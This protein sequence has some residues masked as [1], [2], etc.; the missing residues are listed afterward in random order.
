MSFSPPIFFKK[1]QLSSPL[2]IRIRGEAR[3]LIL[4]E[5]IIQQKINSLKPEELVSYA[6]QY[7]I[8][9]SIN[10][11]KQLLQLVQGK[12]I[13]VFHEEERIALLKQ[14]AK[15]TSP[16]TAKKANQL[17]LQFFNGNWK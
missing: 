11:A 10:E 14:I 8:S 12:K 13:N 4:F 15:I 2:F 5:K 16:E 9:I 6:K 7:D 1:R 3:S 17:F